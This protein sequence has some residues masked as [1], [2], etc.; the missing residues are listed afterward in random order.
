MRDTGPYRR[1]NHQTRYYNVLNV[2]I[3]KNATSWGRNF[4]EKI[5]SVY[6]LKC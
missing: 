1:V 2:V 6:R 3:E 4:P 5:V